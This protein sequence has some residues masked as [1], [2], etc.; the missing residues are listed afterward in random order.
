MK[1]KVE[2]Q[3]RIQESGFRSQE[4]GFRSQDSGV[5]IQDS[6]VRIQESGVGRNAHVANGLAV[7]IFALKSFSSK[8]PGLIFVSKKSPGRAPGPNFGVTISGS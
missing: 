3:A 6:G 2:H 5:R 4:S 1:R 8:R 7:V